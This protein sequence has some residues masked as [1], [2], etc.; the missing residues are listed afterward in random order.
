MLSS[1]A[2]TVKRP[3]S[4]LTGFVIQRKHTRGCIMLSYYKANLV[5][6]RVCCGSVDAVL[7]PALL[8]RTAV[9]SYAISESTAAD[10]RPAY[11][12][13]AQHRVFVG[14]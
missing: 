7:A 6:K 8:I 2:A 9:A 1:T 5:C 13:H 11:G 12:A 14:G 10:T 3:K 4:S